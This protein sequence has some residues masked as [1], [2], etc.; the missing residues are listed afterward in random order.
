MYQAFLQLQE[1]TTGL[2]QQMLQQ[3]HEG[4]QL[5]RAFVETTTANQE[6][7]QHIAQALTA[8]TASM[9]AFQ[10]GAQQPQGGAAAQQGRYYDDQQQAP[11]HRQEDGAQGPLKGSSSGK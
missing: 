3:Q 5:Q 9:D 7:A 1:T 8:V 2:Q 10:R 11:Q 4:Q 6:Q